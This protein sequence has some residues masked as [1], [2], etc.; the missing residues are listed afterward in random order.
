MLRAFRGKKLIIVEHRLM[1]TSACRDRLTA[2]GATVVGP[3]RSVRE[4]LDALMEKDIDAA[5]V[6]IEVDD[7][8]LVSLSLVL[9]NAKVPFVFASRVS[10]IQCGYTLSGQISELRE[11]GDALFGGPGAS[12]TLH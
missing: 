4:V 1:L 6:D 10:P 8:T 3:V 2:A 11:I 9:E 7:E 5:I 12:S